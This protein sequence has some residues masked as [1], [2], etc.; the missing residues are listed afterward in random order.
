MSFASPLNK[1]YYSSNIKIGCSINYTSKRES[2][3]VVKQRRGVF[4]FLMKPKVLFWNL[5]GLNEG[6][7][8]LSVRN[9]LREW[10]VDIVCFQETKL[11]VM[12]HSVYS[13]WGCHHVDQCYL[14]SRG[15]GVG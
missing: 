15:V 8:C 10:K 4:P 1:N 11:E 3:S 12:S 6:D 13:L 2:A 7:K 14:D 9:L 5:R